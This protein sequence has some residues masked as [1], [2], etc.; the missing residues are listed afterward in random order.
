MTLFDWPRK[1]G[2]GLKINDNFSFTL[3]ENAP[4]SPA[5]TRRPMLRSLLATRRLIGSLG[6]PK[7]AIDLLAF[8]F[9]LP[10][11]M[12]WATGCRLFALVNVHSGF[13]GHNI[14]PVCARQQEKK[15]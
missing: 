9:L 4:T 10:I 13:N 15:N 12:V 5:T 14:L 1:N 11:F 6:R 7:W 2:N 8:G 3:R